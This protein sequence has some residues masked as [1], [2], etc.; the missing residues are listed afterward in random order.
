[1]LFGEKSSLAL[2]LLELLDF[3]DFDFGLFVAAPGGDLLF[4]RA[5]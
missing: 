3:D 1:M 2:D 4:C 5:A